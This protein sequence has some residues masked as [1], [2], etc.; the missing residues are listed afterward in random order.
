MIQLA[1]I[2]NSPMEAGMMKTIALWAIGIALIAY[3]LFGKSIIS[4][5]KSWGFSLVA[6]EIKAT[7]GFDITSLVLNLKNGNTEIPSTLNPTSVDALK[8]KNALLDA[9]SALPPEKQLPVARAA[10]SV[11][12]AQLLVQFLKPSV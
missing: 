1:A 6:K 4:A 10:S 2:F 3:G 8:F 11:E 7:T 12:E 9:V 5:F